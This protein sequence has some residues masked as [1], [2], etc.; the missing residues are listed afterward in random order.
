VEINTREHF[1]VSGTEARAFGVRSPWFEGEAPVRTY[2][3][4]ELLA[5]K[6]RALFQ[7][8]KGRDLFDLWA[9]LDTQPVDTARIVEVFLAYMKAERARVSRK[10]FEE[11]L[12]A[13]VASRAFNEDLRPLLSPGLRYAAAV[14]ADLVRGRL[15]SR[16]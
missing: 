13:K 4:E 10:A 9:A 11:N 14:A 7:R 6:L 16:L 1:S 8:R 12:A 2:P 3:L 5:T 15:L